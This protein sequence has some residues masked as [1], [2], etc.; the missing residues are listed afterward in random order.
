MKR[1]RHSRAAVDDRSSAVCESVA[2]N[3]GGEQHMFSDLHYTVQKSASSRFHCSKLSSDVCY[4]TAFSSSD[5]GRFEVWELENV[6]KSGGDDFA[7]YPLHNH[8]LSVTPASSRKFVGHGDTIYDASF[9]RNKQNVI[10]ASADKSC[11]LWDIKSCIPIC[12]FECHTDIVWSV[13]I[14]ECSQFIATGSLDKTSV[15][16]NLELAK[17]CR[18]LI[19]H[20]GS[21]DSVHFAEGENGQQLFTTCLDG[22]VKRWDLRQ[23][24]C[25]QTFEN[26]SHGLHSVTAFEALNAQSMVLGSNEGKISVIDFRKGGSF[27]QSAVHSNRITS[28]LFDRS[29][30]CIV[31]GSLDNSVCVSSLSNSSSADGLTVLHTWMLNGSTV[32]DLQLA[33]KGSKISK[34]AVYDCIVS[35]GVKMSI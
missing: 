1:R 24:V 12:K 29:S 23:A 13:Q 28:V 8:V 32:N 17:P 11:I 3:R 30:T 9:S 4:L 26:K 20:N 7:L 2:S 18:M 34:C 19:G 10:T 6:L 14:S 27:V 15:I 16:W 5:R 35:T 33:P 25:A 22:M 21:V 31:S